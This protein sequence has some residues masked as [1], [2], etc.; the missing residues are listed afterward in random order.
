M[1]MF[2]KSIMS[3]VTPDQPKNGKAC[4]NLGAG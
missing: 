4:I 3:M 2:H 1:G